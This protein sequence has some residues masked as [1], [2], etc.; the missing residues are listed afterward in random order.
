M[1][2]VI[3]PARGPE[4]MRHIRELFTEYQQWLGV[5]L[6]FQGFDKEMR[7]LPGKYAG[8][9]GSLLLAR[10][11]EV[12]AGGVGLWPLGDDICEMKRLFVRDPW[13]G[14]GLGRRLA[15]AIIGEAVARGYRRMCLDTLEHLDAAQALYHSLGFADTDPYYD[16]PLDG[17]RYM[18]LDLQGPPARD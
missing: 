5:D 4:D 10:D 1:P 15:V 18:E 13:R 7:A 12:V 3:T 8:P 14:Q 16:N 17:V 6:C 11:G 2:P 9:R